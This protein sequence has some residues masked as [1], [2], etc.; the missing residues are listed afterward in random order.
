MS[1][2]E[3]LYKN[4]DKYTHCSYNEW[5]YDFGLFINDNLSDYEK[6]LIYNEMAQDK[7]YLMWD[8]IEDISNIFGDDFLH[9]Y[10]LIDHNKFNIYDDIIIEE[11][12][13]VVSYTYADFVIEYWDINTIVEYIDKKGVENL[14]NSEIIIDNV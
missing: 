9:V 5:L 8:N 6:C 13:L 7:H 1:K 4:S 2:L 14:I 11:G 10:S 3:E 12:C